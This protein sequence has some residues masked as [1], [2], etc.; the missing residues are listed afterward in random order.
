MLNYSLLNNS[1]NSNNSNNSIFLNEKIDLTRFVQPH[2]VLF[3]LQESDLKILQV[4]QNTHYFFQKN[5]EELLG[6]NLD[7][8]FNESQLCFFRKL[9]QKKENLENIN[10]FKFSTVI[11]ETE[12]FFEGIVTQ[13]EKEKDL[14]ILELEPSFYSEKED[15]LNTNNIKL[16]N[17]IRIATRNINQQDNFKDLC[18]SL[19]Q[20]VQRITN[21]DRVML[22][23]FDIDGHG[24]VI[25]ESIVKEK[26]NQ[27]DPYLGL[28][29]PSSDIPPQA[30]ELFLTNLIR[31]IPDLN[32][33]PVEIFPLINPLTQQP[34]PLNHSVL[35]GVSPCHIEYLKNMEISASLSISLI[36]EKSLWGMIVCH[37][38]TPK[39]V[40]YQIRKACEFLGEVM[41]S[42]PVE[43]EKDEDQKYK[44]KLQTIQNK[45]IE[46]AVQS[47]NFGQE[48][49]KNSP[50][51][52][53]ICDATGAV[54]WH[55]NEYD[56]IGITPTETQIEEIIYILKNQNNFKIFH[57]DCLANIYPDA[58]P[59]KHIACGLFAIAIAPNQYILWFRQHSH[60]AYQ[61]PD[62]NS[63]H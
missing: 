46:F 5:H 22:Y 10:P 25:A 60:L 40:P 12:L 15:F 16:Y 34:I 6:E 62:C 17:L 57:T 35:R 29:F 49:I 58:E 21:F 1:T 52:L 54:F 61:F 51:L 38:Q 20:E 48:L 50:N 8:I 31:F 53:D 3:V 18:E 27:L 45:L 55:H 63:S 26:Q 4:S 56:T 42:Q 32:S 33:E 36:K 2:G 11:N 41:A 37:H 24:Q 47:P 43:Q 9:L 7:V 19:V 44:I 14:I 39:Y 30:K 59:I 13:L 28:H 23:K